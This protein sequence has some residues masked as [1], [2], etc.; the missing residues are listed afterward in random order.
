MSNSRILT[1]A[2]SNLFKEWRFL[3]SKKYAKKSLLFKTL[4]FG[5]CVGFFSCVIF[6]SAVHKASEK[7][8]QQAFAQQE[9]LY[10]ASG[11][12]IL[13]LDQEKQVFNSFL[14]GIEQAEKMAQDWSGVHRDTAVIFSTPS[15]AG[16]LPEKIET[17]LQCKIENPSADYPVCN[18]A[19]YKFYEFY[20]TNKTC[21]WTFCR[22]GSMDHSCIY[23]GS[24]FWG[25][26]SYEWKHSLQVLFPQAEPLARWVGQRY[27]WEIYNLK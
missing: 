15:A 14:S 21:H 10:Q 19:Y 3:F 23:S 27:D 20:C 4:F 24:G 6:L 16:A 12:A 25:R 26:D 1:H 5:F 13:P 17:L 11:E 18:G 22:K 2:V 7:R 9:A 8:R